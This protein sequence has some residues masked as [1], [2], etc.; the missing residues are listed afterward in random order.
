MKNSN[1]TYICDECNQEIKPQNMI[2]TEGFPNEGNSEIKYRAKSIEIGGQQ[3]CDLR[4][5]TNY[6]GKRLGIIKQV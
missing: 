3:F 6:I 1:I 2:S 5:L 4:C